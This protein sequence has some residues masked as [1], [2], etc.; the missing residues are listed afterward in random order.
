MDILLPN[1]VR[2]GDKLGELLARKCTLALEVGPGSTALLALV[3]DSPGSGPMNAIFAGLSYITKMGV[4]NAPCIVLSCDLPLLEDRSL[5]AL[6]GFSTDKSVVPVVE[7]RPQWLCSKI[8]SAG[9]A[10]LTEHR[11]TSSR[12]GDVF[13]ALP[14][15]LLADASEIY[16]DRPLSFS[17]VDNV[18]DLSK[19][20]EKD[21]LS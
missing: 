2:L 4:T 13:S 12:V 14:D 17:D 6:T 11:P 5:S 8:S 3:E 18:A 7:G 16:P 19:L 15:L 21:H 1:G 20:F 9:V 10:W